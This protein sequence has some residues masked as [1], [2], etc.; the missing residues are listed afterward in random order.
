VGTAA[1]MH[2]LDTGTSHP[3]SCTAARSSS[4]SHAGLANI[5]AVVF[6]IQ[7]MSSMVNPL[8]L[9]LGQNSAIPARCSEH[10]FPDAIGAFWSAQGQQ[11][12]VILA[13]FVGNVVNILLNLLLVQRSIGLFLRHHI[14]RED[15]AVAAFVIMSCS[16][17]SIQSPMPGLAQACSTA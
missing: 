10:A 2:K 11:L 8:A 3:S 17:I 14:S 5:S 16:L 6:A 7:L 4:M 1:A 13:Q 9:A 12:G 15:R